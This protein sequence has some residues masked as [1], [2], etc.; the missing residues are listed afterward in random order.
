[1]SSTH[2][3][4][5]CYSNA[6]SIAFILDTTAEMSFLSFFDLRP[7]CML[8]ISFSVTTFC[9]H[10]LICCYRSFLF[11]LSPRHFPFH[12]Y[13]AS[14]GGEDDRKCPIKSII[15]L[16]CLLYEQDFYQHSYCRH[17]DPTQGNAY[18]KTKHV[19]F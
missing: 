18:T 14:L 8:L 7:V 4:Q 17:L 3:A 16:L 13:Q 15:I 6:P 11:T 9:I 2:P 5:Y 10:S 19:A 12:P 1:M